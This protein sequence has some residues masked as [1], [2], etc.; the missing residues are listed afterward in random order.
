MSDDMMEIARLFV[1]VIAVLATVA[2]AVAAWK[3]AHHSAE[4]SREAKVLQERNFKIALFNHR[5]AVYWEM[6]RTLDEV[7]G[8][9]EMPTPQFL[10]WLVERR[11]GFRPA[12]YVFGDKG[13]KLTDEIVKLCREFHVACLRWQTSKS[14][15]DLRP[16]VEAIK[17]ELGDYYQRIE[18]V[19]GDDLT[20]VEDREATA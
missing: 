12:R 3:A 11:R 5:L 9:E 10:D 16:K 8:V 19:L 7:A 18:D 1:S 6:R 14:D 15:H 13:K 17:E 2:A 4:A 20:L